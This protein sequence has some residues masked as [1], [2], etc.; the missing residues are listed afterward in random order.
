MPWEAA[1]KKTKKKS[2]GRLPGGSG[3]GTTIKWERKERAHANVLGRKMMWPGDAWMKIAGAGAKGLG[4]VP[5]GATQ[6]PFRSEVQW[7]LLI[8]YFYFA[9]FKQNFIIIDLQFCVKF[10]LYS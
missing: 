7:E 10:L 2:Q 3:G 5:C 6:T 9:F 1:L 4:V 8:F